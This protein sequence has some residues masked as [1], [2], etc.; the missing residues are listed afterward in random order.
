MRTDAEANLAALIESTED[1][2][3][4]VDLNYGL[5]TFN[6]AFHDNI[7]RNFGIRSALGMRPVDLLSPERA[8]LWTPLYER[9]LSEGAFRAEYLLADGRTL[10]VALNR[11]V[12]DGETTGISVFGKDITERKTAEKILL[13]AERQYRDIFDG[14]IEG[15]Y[16]ISPEGKPLAVNSALAKMLG[17]ESAQEVVSTITDLAH[18][19]WLDPSGRPRFLQLLEQHEVVRGYECQLKRKDGTALWVSLNSRRVFGKDGRALGIEGFIED[20][21]ERK[22][23]QDA[24]RRSEER[25]AQAFRSSPAAMLL[26]KIEGAGNRIIDANEGFERVSGYRR[27]EIIGRTGKELGLFADPRE[28]GEFMK[29]FRGGGRI[30]GFEFHFRR[31]SGEIG[32]GLISAESMELDGEPWMIGATIDITERKAA[33]RDRLQSERQYRSLFNS[34]QEGVA[35]HKLMGSNGVPD[36]YIV[37][38]VNRRF[39]ELLGMKREHVV[40]RLATDVYGTEAAPYLKEYAS[41]VAEGKPFQFETYFPPMDKH[42]FIS[43][44]PMGEDL[45]A[46]IF[47]DITEQKR[48][49]ERYQLISENAADVIWMWDLE[50]GRCAY[51]SPSV[52]Q[53]R[54]FSSEE[55]MAQ[56]MDQAMPGDTCRMATGEIQ[57]RRAAVESGDEGA[58]I[59]TSE[60]EF[61]RKDGTTVATETVTRLVSDG[62]GKVRYLVGV[63]RDITGLKRAEAEKARIEDELRQAQKLES[64]GR[65]AAGV[66]HDF[67]NLLTVINGYSRLLL[68]SLKS[69]DPLRGGLEEIHKAGERA[70]A[71]IQQ[72]LAFSRKQIL[73]PRVLDLNRVVEEM[74]P[75]LVRL[76][77]EDVEVGVQSQAE[78]ATICADP[79]QLE[80]VLMNLAVNS[81]DAMPDGGRFSIETGFVEWDESQAQLHPGA[82]AGPY[83]MLA[84]SDTGEGM[85]EETRGHIF[86]PF[87]TTK[88]VGKGTGLGLSTIHGIVEQS[89]GCIE[90]ASEPGRGT[91]FKIYMPR[92]ADAPAESGRPEAIPEMGGTET[93]LVVEDQ[94]EVREYAAAAL[95]AYGYQVMEAA[96]AEEALVICEREGERIR[97][98]LTDVV[99]PG[100]SGRELADRLKTLRP[101]VKVLFMSGHTDDIMVH[102][103][104]LRKEAGFIQKPFSPDVLAMK[105][106]EILM[107]PDRPA[108]IV[109][110]DDEAGVRSFLRLVLEGAG[111]EVLEAPSGKLALQEARAG[112]VD[113]VITDLVMPEQEG[114]ETIRALCREVPGVGI[115]AISGAL[116]PQFLE[117][118]RMLGAQAVLSKPLSAELLLAKVAEVLKSRR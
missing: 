73:Q 32:T 84:V 65:L 96:N 108:R 24:L 46:T 47:F 95:G 41:V 83:V 26:A 14:A 56:P 82:H 67:N 60:I 77:G 102:H 51:V 87:F 33:E 36:N 22:R 19:V 79:H 90:V 29:Q 17:Y 109:V 89:G 38:D 42:F 63:S 93:V 31:K 8:A 113:L 11:I 78:A 99:M 44:T 98:I 58:R 68:G 76:M 86:E 1:L 94:A 10:E 80:Q 5:L 105:V 7:Q 69:D 62:R 66:A 55:I 12:Q 3:W 18:Q 13:D 70:A 74:R 16:R 53:L 15:I 85:S 112:R 2:I 34:M 52:Q 20:I 104:V 101:G 57:R 6:R 118:A 97:L 107:A 37:L 64:V 61:L 110:A 71:L 106:R 91:T 35:L 54:G 28:Y 117:V 9:V 116:G 115:I 40:D 45:F 81:R 92:V 4:S 21:T 100:L 27:K 48:T 75:M 111:Y 50:E 30:R 72:L 43:V 39:E 25:F 103:G 59:D 49:Q 88:E 114:I 23:T